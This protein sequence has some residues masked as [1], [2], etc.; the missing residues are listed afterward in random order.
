MP[1][2]PNLADLAFASSSSAHT[3]AGHWLPGHYTHWSGDCGNATAL[4]LA[5]LRLACDKSVK[6]SHHGVESSCDMRTE[7]VQKP[8]A[9]HL[10]HLPSNTSQASDSASIQVGTKVSV[11]VLLPRAHDLTDR[12]GRCSRVPQ[13][14][15]IADQFSRLTT[16]RTARE[17]MPPPRLVDLHLVQCV[18]ARFSPCKH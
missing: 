4:A 6:Q 16:D 13:V 8:A 12:P 2:S 15:D 14:M 17:W 5:K 7:L 1:E 11:T 3:E 9:P 10:S 18:S